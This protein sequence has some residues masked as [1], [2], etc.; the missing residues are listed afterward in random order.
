VPNSEQAGLLTTQLKMQMVK[1]CGTLSVSVSMDCLPILTVF[2]L[3]EKP[4][5]NM[6]DWTLPRDVQLYLVMQT[7]W[8]GMHT[9]LK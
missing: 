9:D 4:L 5:Q 3:K 7:D 2:L 1:L 8:L 6:D